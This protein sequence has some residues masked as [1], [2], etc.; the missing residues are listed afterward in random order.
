MARHT[1]LKSG[2][3]ILSKTFSSLG[4]MSVK[5]I[6]YDEDILSKING[7]GRW[8]LFLFMILWLPSAFSAFAVFMYSFITFE[9]PNHHCA[10]PA[11]ENGGVYD[12]EPSN[13]T[14]PYINSSGQWIPDKCLQ[15]RYVLRGVCVSF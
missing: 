12:Y 15:Y 3:Q 14:I 8:Q 11:C 1:Y 4:A 7:F 9:P 2:T 10:I 6:D 5:K 13:F